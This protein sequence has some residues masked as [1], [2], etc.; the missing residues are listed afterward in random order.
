MQARVGRLLKIGSTKK[1]LKG[2][3]NII[4]SGWLNASCGVIKY[5]IEH[6]G[7]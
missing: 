3:C 6:G 2:S 4:K 5:L 7:S 1:Q